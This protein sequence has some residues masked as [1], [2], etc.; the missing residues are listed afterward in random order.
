MKKA[1]LITSLSSLA[2]IS[3]VLPIFATS[4]ITN[5][6]NADE[7]SEQSIKCNINIKSN[8]SLGIITIDGLKLQSYSNKIVM[9]STISFT[10]SANEDCVFEKWSDGVTDMSRTVSVYDDLNL[11]AIFSEKSVGPAIK[12]PPPLKIHTLS[13]DAS[14]GGV[15]RV[16]N[17]KV[18]TPYTN[19]YADN[20][21]VEIYANP[22]NEY[23]FL[24][25]SD[26]VLECTRT[27]KIDKTTALSAFFAKTPARRPFIINLK[28]QT[29]NCYYRVNGEII[30]G[31]YTA[32]F[33]SSIK[34]EAIPA[35]GYRF[36]EWSD[37]VTANPRIVSQDAEL[38]AIYEQSVKYNLDVE[39]WTGGAVSL[40]VGDQEPILVENGNPI[41]GDIV[42]GTPITATAKPILGYK[43]KCWEDNST[44]NTRDMIVDSNKTITAI[45]EDT[46]GYKEIKIADGEGF[47]ADAKLFTTKCNDVDSSSNFDVDDR[48]IIWEPSLDGIKYTDPLTGS[49]YETMSITAHNGKLDIGGMKQDPNTAALNFTTCQEM[50]ERIFEG[51]EDRP[52]DPAYDTVENRH[53]RPGFVWAD[54]TGKWKPYVVKEIRAGAFNDDSLWNPSHGRVIIPWTVDYSGEKAFDDAS[55]STGK[56]LHVVYTKRSGLDI[57]GISFSEGIKKDNMDWTR[58]SDWDSK[59]EI[60]YN[61][62]QQKWELPESCEHGEK[63]MAALM[64]IVN[65]TYVKKEAPKYVFE[66]KEAEGKYIVDKRQYSKY[67]KAFNKDETVEI[68]A[69]DNDNYKF[70]QWSDGV[71]TNPRTITVGKNITL[72]AIYSKTKCVLTL[73]KPTNGSIQIDDKASEWTQTYPVNT[74]LKLTA[75]PANG[76]R[77]IKWSNGEVENPYHITMNKDLELT[78][79][80]ELAPP[81]KYRFY[82]PKVEYGTVKLNGINID[83]PYE[84]YVD[85]GTKYDLE[86]FYDEEGGKYKFTNWYMKKGDE[87]LQNITN[88]TKASITVDDNTLIVPGIWLMRIET[89]HESVYW[90]TPKVARKIYTVDA[91]NLR[92][93]MK[94]TLQSLQGILAQEEARV[95]V[96]T[97][98]K[99][100]DAWFKDMKKT[101]G[102]DTEAVAN[103]WD[104]IEKFKNE[105]NSEYIYFKTDPDNDDIKKTINTA[106]TLAGIRKNIIIGNDDDVVEARK[107]GLTMSSDATNFT[108]AYLFK[109]YKGE[110]NRSMLINQS[111]DNM[112]LRDY[113]IASKSLCTYVEK[114]N[115]DLR[116]DILNWI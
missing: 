20:E 97:G 58:D 61:T 71:T 73:N 101:Y 60:T 80:F 9:G 67:R 21:I 35:I 6:L 56:K 94:A 85:P 64:P 113:A 110:L 92:P 68:T 44:T 76:Y 55:T 70:S 31:S 114:E 81:S 87:S 7:K 50:I 43:F 29:N 72:K 53:A 111:P 23:I 22:D 27:I 93:E 108:T 10:A 13:V 104:L 89:S 17:L 112:G 26:G 75:V 1:K 95:F 39:A 47:S 34:V 32:T 77:F 100:R 46:S 63:E 33:P 59:V 57:N 38:L 37:H 42:K 5:E 78:A 54:N 115:N 36:K 41:H 98:D 49:E 74:Q 66:L 15:I 45:F 91:S 86:V 90:K 88:E 106:C 102:F 12:A 51:L 84:D 82:I 40:T 103:P 48:T 28:E 99:L 4:C 96:Y 52:I 109:T 62:I 24:G 2:A 65:E 116:N 69:V 8:N 30:D 11:I 14:D 25:W 3:I 105:F 19:I 18:E 16:N 107:R 79:I 83:T